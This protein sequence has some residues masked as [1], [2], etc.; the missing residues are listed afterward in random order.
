MERYLTYWLLFVAAV[1]SIWLLVWVI[2]GLRWVFTSLTG[3]WQRQRAKHR[4]S[5]IDSQKVADQA[6]ITATRADVWCFFDS[7]EHI[8]GPFYSRAKLTEYCA[9]FLSDSQRPEF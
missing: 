7:K 8:L 3:D 6:R 5:T 4:Q 9:A 2:H 1:W